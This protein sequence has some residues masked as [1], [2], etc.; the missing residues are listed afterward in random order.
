MNW[1][2]WTVAVALVLAG[3]GAVAQGVVATDAGRV[4]G[5]RESGLA[6]FKGLRYAAPPVGELRW[7]EPQPLAPWQGTQPAQAFGNAC[8]Q[9]PELSID[10]EGGDPRPIAKTACF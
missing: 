6:T 7:R 3:S 10:S 9:K 5:Q 2:G 8:I 4:Q 1:T